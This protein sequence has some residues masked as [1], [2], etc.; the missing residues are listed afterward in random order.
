MAEHHKN[1]IIFALSNPTKNSE[2]DALSA[3]KYTQGRAIFA[4][5]SPFDSVTLEGKVFHPA[6]GNNMYI[7][8]GLGY[9]VWMS[10]AIK[11]TDKMINASSRALANCV[12]KE[13]L[14]EG[15]IYPPLSKIRDISARIAADVF[16]C[17]ADEKFTQLPLPSGDLIE[18]MKQCMYVPDYIPFQKNVV[19]SHL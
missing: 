3:Y 10:Q 17:A 14:A 5:G 13:D 6:Q 18:Y 11:V 19:H 12:T 8:P 4:S 7:F 15:R 16:K 9:G 1:P 2:C